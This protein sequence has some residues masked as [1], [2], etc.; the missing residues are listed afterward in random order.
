MIAT[1]IMIKGNT[2][3]GLGPIMV[4]FTISFMN[5]SFVSLA[6]LGFLVAMANILGG[7]MHPKVS[8]R[9]NLLVDIRINLAF[10]V[11]L[12]VLFG[13]LV[14]GPD[15]WISFAVLSFLLGVHLGWFIPCVR[16]TY[17]AL[18][19]RGQETEYMGIFV[20]VGTGFNWIP[21]LLFTVF[22]ERGIKM[23]IILLGGFIPLLVAVL[24]LSKVSS[25]PEAVVLVK[26][27]DTEFSDNEDA[28]PTDV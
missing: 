24:L 28:P 18:M 4:T 22:N 20:F 12:F 3:Q 13:V 10:W 15:R 26:D 25:Y 21:P 23:N 27:Q 17:Y 2:I 5:G 7:R 19:P 6:L 1:L 14:T 16:V 9:F 11:I 8:A